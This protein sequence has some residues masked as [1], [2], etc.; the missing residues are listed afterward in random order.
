ML[1]KQSKYSHCADFQSRTCCPRSRFLQEQ[2]D[3]EG[4]THTDTHT[5]GSPACG[6]EIS[7]LHDAV[8]DA[9]KIIF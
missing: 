9:V 4:F 1:Q 5:G 8:F 6:I 3:L 2:V 7:Y